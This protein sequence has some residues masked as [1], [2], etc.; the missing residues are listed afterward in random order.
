MD[1]KKGMKEGVAFFL[2]L[3]EAHSHRVLYHQYM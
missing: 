2:F 3:S 1:A